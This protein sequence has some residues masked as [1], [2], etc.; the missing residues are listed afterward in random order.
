V[1]NESM[2]RLASTISLT[3]DV[4]TLATDVVAWEAA[5]LDAVFV[6]E[7]Y[8]FDAPSLLGYLA[9]RTTTIQLGAGALSVFSRTPALVAMTAAGLD[10]VSQ[11]RFLL[12]LGASGPQVV[13]G[14]HGQAFDRP[15][16][17]TEELI[18][19]CRR[20]WAREPLSTG[21]SAIHP[22]PRLGSNAPTLKLAARP[23]R[24]RIPIYLAGLGQKNVELAAAKADGWLSFLLAPEAAEATWGEAISAGL[25]RRPVELGDLDIVAGGPT[26]I[27]PEPATANA[28]RV[29]IRP[30]VA[31]YLGGMGSKESNF[32]NQ[33]VQRY[34]YKVEA[35]EIQSL[36]LAGR[37]DEAAAAVPDEL[38]AR[39]TLIG[40]ESEVRTRVQ[41]YRSA[42]VRTLAIE[43]VSGID[44]VDTVRRM[45]AIVDTKE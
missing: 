41:Q 10:A 14:L 1:A 43:P 15:V 38:L 16:G 33:L 44:H 19:L 27:V 29:A 4:E 36:F 37:R 22:I 6:G 31:L 3:D 24:S 9:A 25:A 21:S 2:M 39:I 7:A 26:A 20:A 13:E 18:D 12:G 40:T 30:Q 32:Y 17:R 42:G 28:L 45:R 5:G 8:G 35:R 23:R 34:G 11:G